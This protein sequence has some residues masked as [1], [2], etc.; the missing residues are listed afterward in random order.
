[1]TNTN[2]LE[3]LQCPECASDG[4]MWMTVVARFLMYDDGAE[5][6]EDIELSDTGLCECAKCGYTDRA[7]RFR[8]PPFT[9][10]DAYRLLGLADG[11][12]DQWAERAVQSGRRDLAYEERL[13]EWQQIRP[14]L[15]AAPALLAV[16]QRLM[17]KAD[18]L[19][20]AI[21]SGTKQIEAQTAALSEACSTAEFVITATQ[22]SQEKL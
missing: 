11:F 5:E 14:L 18:D 4:P 7:D 6:H 22:T 17:A 2:C 13:A 10:L 3:G 20:A 15:Q 19:I 12:L 9:R 1:M 21:D 8:V 16:L